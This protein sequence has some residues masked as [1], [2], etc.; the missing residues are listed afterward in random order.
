MSSRPFG[1]SYSHA[2]DALYRDKDYKAECDFLEAAIA[3][4]GS[5][6]HRTVLDLGC[7]TGGHA[8][9]L[10]RRGYSVTGVDV[11]PAMLEIARNKVNQSAPDKH[12]HIEFMLGDVETVYL[13]A[14]F[15]SAIMMF[16]VLGY[17]TDTDRL[18][19]ALRNV[20]RQLRRGGIFIADFWYGP[21][22]MK[23]PP[24]DRVRVVDLPGRTIVR[25]TGAELDT[26][27]QIA[28]IHFDLYDIAERAALRK[29][30]ETHPMR[31]FFAQELLLLCERAEFSLR[32]L[33]AFPTI[34]EHPTESTWN[35][36]IIAEAT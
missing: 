24:G 13:G 1:E 8:I 36:A 26:F 7:G 19:R 25:V 6:A 33:C 5:G 21:A 10:G 9:E 18:A 12:Q 27:K 23:A 29:S 16:A 15:D 20:R 4:Y 30:S 28:T 34:D 32:S 2:Y 31:Y 11:S 3:R 22:V 17:L 14:N 35:V